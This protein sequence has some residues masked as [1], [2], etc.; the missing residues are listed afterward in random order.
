MLA[1]SITLAGCQTTEIITPKTTPQH[2][3]IRTMQAD[4][5]D[6]DGDGVLDSIDECPETPPYTVV[7]AKGCE[8]I[9]EGGEAL[10]MEFN[11][12]FPPMSSQ[13]PAIYDADFIKMAETINEY[14]EANVFIFGHAAL[15]EINDE[16]LANFGFNSLA[17]NRALI[18]KNTLVLQHDI[19]AERI[20]TYECSNKYLSIDTGALDRNF[21]ALKLKNIKSKQS[22]VTLMA[23]SNVSD[24]MNLEY[25]YYIQ[26]Y[27]E[28]AKH[29][30]KF[31]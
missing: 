24:L 2:E 28:Y 11:G 1:A 12:F 21:K 17:R 6:S 27:G 13:L 9:I 23:S 16:S 5:P 29:C 3:N 22:R 30:D 26:R 20:R 15:N 14:P 10:E 25:D 19:T 31:E 8:I 18:I 7:D 4:I